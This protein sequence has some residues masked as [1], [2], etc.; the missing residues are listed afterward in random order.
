MIIIVE[1]PD[2]AGKTTIIKQLMESLPGSLYRHFSNPKTKEEADNYWKVYAEAVSSADPTKVH[3]FDRSWYSDVVYGPIFRGRL[4]MDPMHVKMLEALVKTH[5][6]GFVIYCT[7]PLKTLWS[8]C[9]QRGE[10]F[11]L[12]KDKLDEVSRS[13]AH[14]MATQ[15]GLPVIR[16]DTGAAW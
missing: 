12:S 14:V 1:G 11:V 9:K 5:G 8:R 4:E 16:Y 3:I 13:Y 6:G 15:C 2:G 10:T 7:A